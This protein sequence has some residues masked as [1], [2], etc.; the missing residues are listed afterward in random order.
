M[1]LPQLVILLVQNSDKP[2]FFDHGGLTAFDDN[3]DQVLTPGAPLNTQQEFQQ[4]VSQTPPSNRI[5]N[6]S[7][8]FPLHK[9]F[10]QY[11]QK[12]TLY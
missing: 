3:K 9:I 5:R 8:F 12:K 1:G 4:E 7:D 10:C 11:I 6:I 2:V